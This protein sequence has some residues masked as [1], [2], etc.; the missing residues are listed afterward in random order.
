MTGDIGGGI[1]FRSSAL[2]IDHHPLGENV[3]R[4]YIEASFARSAADA[5]NR[6]RSDFAAL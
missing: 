5:G 3:S 6:C 2:P 4:T 1:R